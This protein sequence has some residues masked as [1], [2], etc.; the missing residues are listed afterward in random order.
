MLLTKARV[1][2]SVHMRSL[3]KRIQ[4]L[5]LKTLPKLKDM[6]RQNRIACV[7]RQ[8]YKTAS[9]PCMALSTMPSST[10]YDCL[11]KSYS[12]VY[13]T[14]KRLFHNY[15]A[16]PDQTLLKFPRRAFST[17]SLKSDFE[18]TAG[19]VRG[20]EAV[21]AC[22]GPC[23]C[24]GNC[25]LPPPCNTP[26]KCLQYMTG[27]YYYP[28]GSWFCGPY[29][30]A[31]GPCGPCTGPVVPGGPSGPC[32]PCTGGPCGP[33]G[34]SSCCVCGPCRPLGCCG[35]CGVATPNGPSLPNASGTQ[36]VPFGMQ[37]SMYD[38]HSLN[39]AQY[40]YGPFP[41]FSPYPP[42]CMP[43][44]QTMMPGPSMPGPS[45]PGPSMPGPS[46]PDP[47]MPDPSMP[48]PNMPSPFFGPGVNVPITP[49][50][51]EPCGPI[52]P[53]ILYN[54]SSPKPKSSVRLNPNYLQE[55]RASVLP[56]A[57]RF[58]GPKPPM[59]STRTAPKSAVYFSKT[60]TGARPISTLGHPCS[61]NLTPKS[62]R[63]SPPSRYDAIC[64]LS[65]NNPF[66]KPRT[67]NR[68]L[69]RQD[70]IQVC[71]YTTR[72][73]KKYANI[74]NHDWQQVK[75]QRKH[76]KRH[77]QDK[78]CPR[79]Q[80]VDAVNSKPLCYWCLLCKKNSRPCQHCGYTT[81]VHKWLPIFNHTSNNET[82]CNDYD[83]TKEK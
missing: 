20:L 16:L 53:Q 33:S 12:A 72:S 4:R 36:F 40:S 67:H 60:R 29:H 59:P 37:G 79:K 48:D 70:T 24:S 82:D 66:N 65:R 62:L 81:S 47:N 39:S 71:Y 34:V 35:I 3:G 38:P 45:M 14:D 5:T 51:Q 11:L 8:P 77:R 7:L 75:I 22:P 46:M 74:A 21:C 28:Y 76:L 64:A 15:G 56:A 44:G 54:P 30:V 57:N 6:R 23:P 83:D 52:T 58:S 19:S 26:P 55:T 42:D 43:W 31:T 49:I 73:M 63:Q 9:C 78:I 41:T 69:P 80:N 18:Q 13:A 17:E 2:L 32:G 68:T 1:I 25:S 27:Y 10:C 61:S 50:S